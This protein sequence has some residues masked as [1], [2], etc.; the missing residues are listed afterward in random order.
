[1]IFWF[2]IIFVLLLAF[3]GVVLRGAPY[4]PTLDAQAKAA[5]ELLDL[6]PGPDAVG[7]RQR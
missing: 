7:T 2:I 5:L 4:V 6:Q 1:M 3:A